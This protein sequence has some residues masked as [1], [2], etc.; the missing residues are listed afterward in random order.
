M[1]SLI[2][3]LLG[4]APQAIFFGILVLVPR[5][6]SL[7]GIGGRRG[8]EPATCSADLPP[9]SPSSS[10]PP[11]PQLPPPTTQKHAPQQHYAEAPSPQRKPQ[12][13][14]KDPL[15]FFPTSLILANFSLI[16][17]PD[18]DRPWPSGTDT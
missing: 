2:W 13:A 12:Q 11:E 4:D 1:C 17:E 5:L 3:L 16:P 7:L 9:P 10:A 15:P 6:L 8:Y 14:R 18:W